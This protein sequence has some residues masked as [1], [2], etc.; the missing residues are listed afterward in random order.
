MAREA[1]QLWFE[2]VGL[3]NDGGSGYSK[4]RRQNVGGRLEGCKERA[5]DEV[6]VQ[7]V[8]GCRLC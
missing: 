6:G 5:R 4:K 7:R 8:F 1:L 3:L 2:P